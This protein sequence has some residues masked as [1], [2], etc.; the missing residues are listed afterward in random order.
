[1]ITKFIKLIL[2]LVPMVAFSHGGSDPIKELSKNNQKLSRV[3]MAFK[4][5]QSTAS[6]YESIEKQVRH[7]QNNVLIL[8]RLMASDYPHV[9]QKMS[10]Y[11]LDYINELD[12]SLKVFKRTLQQTEDTLEEVLN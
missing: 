4:N 10:K 9:D 6:R 7:L 11:Q 12:K 2:F 3:Q 1:M 8:R 5:L